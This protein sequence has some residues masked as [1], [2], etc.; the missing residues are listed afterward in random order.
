MLVWGSEF[1]LLNDPPSTEWALLDGNHNSRAW[2]NLL[3]SE[4]FKLRVHSDSFF[5]PSVL[6]INGFSSKK[7]K[8]L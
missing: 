3:V 4:R 7:P 5:Y 6:S 8:D 1:T 2:W